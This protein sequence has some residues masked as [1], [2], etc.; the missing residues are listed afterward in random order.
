MIASFM[1]RHSKIYESCTSLGLD[2]LYLRL[3]SLQ[4]HRILSEGEKKPSILEYP[5]GFRMKLDYKDT[6]DFTYLL[7]WKGSNGSYEIK[8]SSYLKKILKRGDSF[9]D[10]GAHAGYFSM[11]ASKLTGSGGKV[12][13]FEPDPVPFKKLKK[14]IQINRL[15]NIRPYEVGIGDADRV[16][17][18][19]L[20]DR[21]SSGNSFLSLNGLSNTAIKVKLFRLDTLFPNGIKNLKAMKLD[22]EGYEN[23]AIIGA[24][25]LIRKSKPTIIFEFN[26][27]ILFEKD[28]RYNQVFDS[29]R[30]LGYSKFIE[31]ETGNSVGKYSDLSHLYTNVIAVGR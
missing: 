12:Y 3:A 23:E 4:E 1:L 29:L 6:Y 15:H 22:L 26:Y 10:G 13:A 11:L 18:F 8:T 28:R 7:E 14:N 20:S 16:A 30:D 25:N 27:R 31:S 24:R 21:D 9:I 2:T 19:N 17:N 5:E